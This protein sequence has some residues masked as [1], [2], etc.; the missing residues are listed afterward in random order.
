MNEREI[1]NGIVMA[2]AV[3]ASAWIHQASMAPRAQTAPH[4]YL[5]A[6]GAG[7]A[8][9]YGKAVEGLNA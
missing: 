4:E 2:A 3:L 5:Q 8:L 9:I 6:V 1:R 7:A